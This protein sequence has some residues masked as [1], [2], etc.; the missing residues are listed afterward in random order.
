MAAKMGQIEGQR[1]TNPM[2]YRLYALPCKGFSFSK[3]PMGHW[4]DISK[5]NRA[6]SKHQASEVIK[7]KLS[8]LLFILT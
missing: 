5:K 7:G 3:C 1:I 4:W 6:V 2:V 8:N